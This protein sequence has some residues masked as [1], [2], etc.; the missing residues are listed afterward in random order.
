MRINREYVEMFQDYA[1]NKANQ[2]DPGE[3]GRSVCE[4][5]ASDSAQWFIDAIRQR[6]PFVGDF[7]L[8]GDEAT[9]RPMIL[10]M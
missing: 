6:H 1:G 7:F 2:D 10:S 3:G 8:T 5:E 9:L 4:A